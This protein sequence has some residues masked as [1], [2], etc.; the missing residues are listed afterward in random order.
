MIAYCKS[1]AVYDL[2]VE[3]EGLVAVAYGTYSNTR[4]EISLNS[5][6]DSTR[7]VQIPHNRLEAGRPYHIMIAIDAGRTLAVAIDGRTV[8]NQPIPDG[9][10]VNRQ[11]RLGGGVGHVIIQKVIIS[12]ESR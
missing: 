11:V 3:L 6:G 5:G 2:F 9:V 12:Q 10:S 8:L 4:T 1:D 7:K